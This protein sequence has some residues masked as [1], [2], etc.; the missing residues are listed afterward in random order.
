[1]DN[2]DDVSKHLLANVVE[3]E[4]FRTRPYQDSL[5]IT[6]IGH[7]LT[8]ISED[9]SLVVV[10]MRLSKIQGE[11][12]D[13]F[14]HF[15]KLPERIQDCLTEMAYQMGTNG[16]MGFKNMISAIRQRDYT[17]A[18]RHGLDSKWARQTPERAQ[19]MMD[20]LAA[21]STVTG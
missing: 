19:D 18:A 1:M 20:E 2:F 15:D 16:L 11:L 3:H 9:E 6:T 7:G 10:Q 14:A 8:W 4:G 5:G 13:T 17:L 21:I 12:Q